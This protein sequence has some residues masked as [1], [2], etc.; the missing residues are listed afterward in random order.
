MS[1]SPP[2]SPVRFST[3]Y[4]LF[5]NP[6]FSDREDEDI[7][8]DSAREPFNA[9]GGGGG[10]G[11]DGGVHSYDVSGQSGDERMMGSNA[12]SSNSGVVGSGGSG[13]LGGSVTTEG[14]DND[15]F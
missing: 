15:W 8:S 13:V 5:N 12:G 9:R 7:P 3:P 6:I 4:P 14:S 2:R 1:N 11:G 10:R